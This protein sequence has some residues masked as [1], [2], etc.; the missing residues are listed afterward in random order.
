MANDKAEK[1]FQI[2]RNDESQKDHF[3]EVLAKTSNPFPW[4]KPLV[5]REYFD[6]KNN[7]PPQ[8]VP[9]QKGFFT[10]PRWNV[11]GYLENVAK[12]NSQNPSNDITNLLVAVVHSIIDYRKETGERT[13]NWITDCSIVRIIFAFPI[14]K[15]TEEHIEFIRTSL[16]SKWKMA[17]LF[18]SEIEKTAFPVLIQHEEKSLLLKLLDIVLDYQQ[19]DEVGGKKYVSVIEE[20][21]LNDI[22]E[23]RKPG[24]AKLCA[25]EAAEV[26]LNKIRAVVDE[27]IGGFSTA[28]IPTIEDH[29]QTHFSNSYEGQLVC[30]VRDMYTVSN[31]KQLREKIQDLMKEEH[32]ILKRIAVYTINQ[33]YKE[34]K[35]S[36][37]GWEGN[38]LDVKGLKHELYELMKNNCHSF[39][40]E[41]IQK[42][43]NWIETRNYF[44]PQEAEE[45]GHRDKVLAY[46]KRE[47]LSAILETK[48]PDVISAYEKYESI[49]PHELNHPGFDFW[50]E[51]SW[52]RAATPIDKDALLS[53]SNADLAR[54][55]TDFKGTGKWEEPTQEDLSIAFRDCVSSHPEQFSTDLEP[56]LQVGR[57]YQHA[58]IWGLYDA[59][60]AGKSYPWDKVLKFVLELIMSDEFWNEAQGTTSYDYRNQ[61]IAQ[62]ADLIE[63]GTRD[64]RHAFETSLLSNAEE[65]LLV[66]IEKTK[67]DTEEDRDFMFWALNSLKGRIFSA[68][69]SYS[70]RYAR[71][72]GEEEERWAKAIKQYFNELLSAP[73][74]P[75]IEF[76]VTLGRYLPSLY[77]HLDKDWVVSNINRILPADDE[78]TWE[79]AFTG[80]LYSTNAVYSDLYLLL[81]QNGH[82]RKGLGINFEDKHCI[83]RIA[84]HICVGYLEEMESLEDQES[85]ISKLIW[86]GSL[87]QV[88]EVISFFWMLRDKMTDK[89]RVKVR[90]LWGNLVKVL[91]QNKDDPEYRKAISDLSRWLSLI[92]SIDDQV[93]EWLKLS[94]S[95]IET[96]F[97]SSFLIEYLLAHA[98][99]TPEKVGK[100]ILHMLGTG[101]YPQ[102]KK[103]NVQDI[104]RELYAQGQKEI[105]DSICN[106]YLAKGIDF[107]KPIYEQNNKDHGKPHQ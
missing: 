97:N 1:I 81:R 21:W 67:S 66:L 31:P 104:V 101:V 9:D 46:R 88:S 53:K 70:L 24:I 55:L 13:D 103:E 11:L 35:D 5:E 14:E 22:L 69:I 107:L 89:I 37:W 64:D 43:L 56:F 54:Y 42:I 62:I 17:S 44:V 8:E 100:I 36:F 102:Y 85:L 79:A 45:K 26:A 96:N 51:T 2:I 50:M 25:T 63:E 12:L 87:A 38:P 93:F 72:H 16:H 92:D 47:W 10:I 49:E 7:P 65:I 73:A 23:K 57:L 99:K 28:M 4:L 75:P 78:K 48:D 84:D 76:S 33:H 58:L 91:S 52:G 77:Y 39:S 71:L 18:A 86:S 68:M 90:P 95:Y 34:L 106:S 6:P 30:F 41:Q 105:A 20:Y 29:P 40:K 19:K 80:Y 32:P 3:F 83:Q 74:R 27:D 98:A 94:A 82:Y 60:H 59:W 61:T 15:I